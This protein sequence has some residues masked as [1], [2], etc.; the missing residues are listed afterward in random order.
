MPWG[1]Y[2]ST[3]VCA[4]GF[5]LFSI[6]SSSPRF[7]HFCIGLRPSRFLIVPS[8][9]QSPWICTLS[10]RFRPRWLESCPT[11]I[12][13]SRVISVCPGLLAPW[14][15]FVNTICR[16]SRFV[17]LRA[18]LSKVW[19]RVLLISIG[20]R[21]PRIVGVGKE[22]C[23]IGCSF[24]CLG[25]LAPWFYNVTE[26]MCSTWISL[27]SVRCSSPRS[28]FVG[29][30]FCHAWVIFVTTRHGSTRRVPFST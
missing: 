21:T 16:P 19:I 8:Q 7:Q 20:L 23:A 25:L 4:P 15:D 18:W 27:F 22:L 14:C 11:F 9:L 5:R 6:W 3:S 17:R 29:A 24:V 12:R 2:V 13:A 10:A 28:S 1:V 30:R 26:V